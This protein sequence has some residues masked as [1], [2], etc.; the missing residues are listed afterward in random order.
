MS[1]STIDFGIDLGTTNSAIAVLNG[2]EPQ[3]IK[4]VDDQDVTPSAVFINKQG[5][6]RVGT[7]AKNATVG[8]RSY[9]D[10]YVEFKRQMGTPHQYRFGSSGQLRKPE[11]LSSEVLKELRRSVEAATGEAIQ[12]AVITVPAAFELHQCDA[13]RRAA[14]LAGL[15]SSPLL[16]E[17]VAAALAYGFQIDSEKAYWLVY[18]FGGGTFDA[19]LIRAEEGMINVVHHGGDNFLGGSD[20]DWAIV[21]KLIAPQL[22]RNYDLPDFNRG[23]DRWKLVL[24]RIKHAVENAKIELSTKHK[25]TLSGGVTFEDASGDTIECDELIVT[26]DDLI[27]IA[28]PIIIRS[29][30][31][32]RKV[33]Q[34]KNLGSHAVQKVIVVGGPTKAPY[35]RE[36][37][38]SGLGIPI[39]FSQDPLTVVA[40][41]AAVFSGTQKIDAKL[42]RKATVGEFQVNISDKYKTVGHDNDP[43]IAGKVTSPSGTSTSGFT[44][45]FVNRDTKWRSGQVPLNNEGAF[46]A[47][48]LAEKGFRNT[49]HIEIVD[50]QGTHQ[51]PVPDHVVYTIGAVIE[52]QPLVKSIGLAKADNTVDVFFKSGSGL[53]QKKRW[54]TAYKTT[55]TLKAGQPG[56]SIQIPI[57]EGEN[58]HADRNREIGRLIIDSSMIKRDLPMGADMELTLRVSESRTLI[59]ETYFPLLDEEFTKQLEVEKASADPTVLVQTLKAEKVRL[60]TLKGKAAEAEESDVTGELDKL[61]ADQER[62]DVVRAAKGDPAAAE[63]AQARL[64]EF[65]LK[66]DSVEE[67]LKWPTLVSEARE[68]QEDLK[69]L[70][71][72]H[73]T[74]AQRD[75]V[76][77]W[78]ELVDSIIT[79]KQ[80]DRLATRIR[81][82]N[83]LYAQILFSLPGFWVDQFR[84][85]ERDRSKFQDVNAAERLLERGRNYLQ[86]NNIDG[87]QDV[88]R[89]LW[90]LLPPDEAQKAQRGIGA[91]IL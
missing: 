18:D 36:M 85:L 67:K 5:V 57:I 6:V 73:G 37:L 90:N 43:L 22:I 80:T 60:D 31:I 34:E 84:R 3:I 74:G 63:K 15:V 33:L 51:K 49:F 71:S 89:K 2:V 65:Q 14:E 25:T 62:D 75:K 1:R 86:Q 58:E 81:E 29:V 20:I 66:L 69:K 56:D 78:S 32:C 76:E 52:E 53:P 87:L 64:L 10:A 26:R 7:R 17:P 24:M 79:K 46:M 44:I 82:G 68:L 91:T 28:E 61:E 77:D 41:G 72:E 23:S 40:R 55:V 50:P 45:E 16:Q 11:D 8:D 47:N 39:D 19:A 83:S 13:T 35:F 88:V 59:L 38:A 70:A 9:E 27:R 54:P 48:L 21:E 12:S 30:D 42:Q 4:N